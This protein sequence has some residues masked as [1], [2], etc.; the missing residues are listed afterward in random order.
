MLFLAESHNTGDPTP[1]LQAEGARIY[2]LQ[3]AGIV[4]T[5]LLKADRSGAIVLLRAADAA[6][7]RDALSSLPLVAN[8]ITSFGEFTAVIS[9]DEARGE[10]RTGTA[11]ASQLPAL[12]GNYFA[13]RTAQ[14][15]DGTMAYISPDMITY[16][17]A[18]LGMA[19][20]SYAAVK[21]GFEQ[22]MPTWAPPARSYPTKILAGS[23]SALVYLTD[24]PEMFG[25]ELRILAAVD[26]ADGKIVRWIDY[27]DASAYDVGL[28]GQ[29]RAPA[30]RFPR[31][32][33]DAKV[34][35]T[36]PA[37]LTRAATALHKAFAAPD[38]SAAAAAMHTDV[39]FTDMAL[40][41]QVIGRIETVRYLERVL[42]RVPYG[43]GSVLR[44]VVGGADGGGFE[45]TAG[46]GVGHL[47]GITALELG[48]DGLITA[49][50]SVYDSRQIDPA[51][52]RAL[53]E[54][55]FA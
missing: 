50:T 16:T 15:V 37:E 41:T 6:T 17:D 53:L 39:V 44:H 1:Y 31:D 36:A 5:V 3:Q 21:A 34:A 54:A 55:S 22:Y 42:G 28:Y 14:D 46:P 23:E 27:W 9:A 32:M 13:A 45:W 49:I 47:A 43:Q 12:L 4:E 25:G 10:S 29:M 26:F 30:D 18:T 35:T 24:T 40:R 51:S 20:D 7:A 2:E 11:S 48:D 52:K 38:A 33:K 8:G 19:L